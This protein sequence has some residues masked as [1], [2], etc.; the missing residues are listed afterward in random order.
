[1][2][3]GTNTYTEPDGFVHAAVFYCSEKEYLDELGPFV[4]GGLDRDDPV[5]VAVPANNQAILR[6]GLGAL[7]AKVT[8]VD[9]TEVGHH[10]ARILGGVLAAFA[11]EHAGRPV[12]MVGEPIWPGRSLDKYPACVRHEALI[13]SAF[14]GCAGTTVLC[15]YDATG[16]DESILADARITHPLLWQ[17]GTVVAT[18]E[19]APK[20]ALARY[21][22]PTT[23]TVR[24]QDAGRLRGSRKTGMSSLRGRPALTHTVRRWPM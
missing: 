3:M 18:A 4:M 8:M 22:P 5:L 13:N 21:Q 19:Y 10:P 2:E 6:K 20:E 11:T 7:C 24:A 9:M 15:P 23:T 16:L 17:G 14:A 1:M 12:R